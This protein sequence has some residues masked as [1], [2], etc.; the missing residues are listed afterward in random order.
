[1][2]KT[3]T[4]LL[5]KAPI[6]LGGFFVAL[7]LFLASQAQAVDVKETKDKAWIR[8]QVRKVQLTKVTKSR[9]AIKRLR[10]NSTLKAALSYNLVEKLKWGDIKPYT[11]KDYDTNMIT[12]TYKYGGYKYKDKVVAV[13]APKSKTIY[14]IHCQIDE[15][16]YKRYHPQCEAFIQSFDKKNFP[17]RATSKTAK[18]SKT[19]DVAEHDVIEDIKSDLLMRAW[20]V[21]YSE[22]PKKTSAMNLAND[23]S[24]NTAVREA[25]VKDILGLSSHTNMHKV[26][27]D[28]GARAKK[29]LFADPEKAQY[30]AAYLTV[31]FSDGYDKRRAKIVFVNFKDKKQAIA[32]SGDTPVVAFNAY[33]P[34]IESFFQ[35]Y[36]ADHFSLRPMQRN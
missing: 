32:L 2:L 3:K 22:N 24:G 29:Y 15:K 27:F 20:R 13:A 17:F 26:K 9:D 16:Y 21:D 7:G 19:P 4:K 14:L 8:T 6:L 11:L 12:A 25:I 23:A 31:N 28:H 34:I 30:E 35:D 10:T 36:E 33:S 18:V 5:K 1:M